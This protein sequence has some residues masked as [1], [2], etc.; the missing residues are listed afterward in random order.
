MSLLQQ[1]ASVI[2]FHSSAPLPSVRSEGQA[3]GQTDAAQRD[4]RSVAKVQLASVEMLHNGALVLCNPGASGIEDADLEHAESHAKGNQD[5]KATKESKQ[6][7]AGK[8]GMCL[9]VVR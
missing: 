3:G 5:T 2:V 1:C 4:Q 9:R 7:E 8:G 6:R